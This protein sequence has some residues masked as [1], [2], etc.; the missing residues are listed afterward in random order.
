M[1]NI[2]YCVSH[3]FTAEELDERVNAL[4]KAG[5]QPVNEVSSAVLNKTPAVTLHFVDM[6]SPE[7]PIS[8]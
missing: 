8:K 2:L 7:V 6:T 4:L 1:N 5:C 3:G